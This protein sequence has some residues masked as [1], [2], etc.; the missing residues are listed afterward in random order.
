MVAHAIIIGRS[1][2]HICYPNANKWLLLIITVTLCVYIGVQA[3]NGQQQ[4][5][6]VS[7]SLFLIAPTDS[8]K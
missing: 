4:S 1:A 2:Y 7:V 6:A 8:G 3:E 5:E